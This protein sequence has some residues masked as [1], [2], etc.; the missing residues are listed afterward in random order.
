MILK[1]AVIAMLSAVLGIAAG[2]LNRP[3]PAQSVATA[4]TEGHTQ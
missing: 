3:V 4:T 2:S 1:L